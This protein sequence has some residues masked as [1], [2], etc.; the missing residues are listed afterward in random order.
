MNIEHCTITCGN[1]ELFI[2]NLVADV[3]AFDLDSAISLRYQHPVIELS[4]NSSEEFLHADEIHNDSILPD[5]T[6][7][8]RVYC[9]VMSV[10]TTAFGMHGDDMGSGECDLRG[11]AVDFQSHRRWDTRR[12]V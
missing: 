1:S 7:D 10:K 9:I 12:R 3:V 6:L 8:R 5:A 11:P 4:C 2:A